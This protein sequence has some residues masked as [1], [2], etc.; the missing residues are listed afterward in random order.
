MAGSTALPV[1]W[2]L[3]SL[4]DHDT[5]AGAWSPVTRSVHSV[6]GLEFVPRPLPYGERTAL[7][8]NPLDPAQTCPRCSRTRRAMRTR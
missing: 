1:H 2:Y 7:P 8:G 5:H 4:A 3:R 6:C